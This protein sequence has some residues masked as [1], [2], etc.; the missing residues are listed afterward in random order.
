MTVSKNRRRIEWSRMRG[1]RRW[2]ALWVATAGGSGLLPLAPGTWGTMAA[3]PLALALDSWSFAARAAFWF[4]L[5]ALGTWS[6]VV[7][8]ETNGTQDNQNIVIDEVV[9]YGIT[10]WHAHADPRSIL[11]AFVLFRFFDMVK[12]WPVHRVDAWS[13]QHSK[14]GSA[15][16]RA[17]WTGF[18]VMA[19]D[20]LAGVLALGCMTLLQHLGWLSS[21]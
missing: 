1:P 12:P 8:D 5:F 17:W 19:D 4:A 15:A 21:G 6:A 10:A 14:Q 9:G 7:F 18:G 13:H 16:Q 3:I 2:A 11:A 20:A